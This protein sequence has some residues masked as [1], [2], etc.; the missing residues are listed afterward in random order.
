MSAE[1]AAKSAILLVCEGLDT[2]ATVYINGEEVGRGVNQFVRY[3]YN[4]G[5]V[6]VVRICAVFIRN[7]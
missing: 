7:N 5:D 3:V 2:I 1:L 4:I 6:I